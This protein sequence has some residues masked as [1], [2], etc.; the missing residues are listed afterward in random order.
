MKRFR[1]AGGR[2]TTPVTEYGFGVLFNAIRH[3]LHAMPHSTASTCCVPRSS[4]S[5]SVLLRM[6]RMLVGFN[7]QRWCAGK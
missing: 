7:A 6:K 1:E 4:L 5:G 2:M 3:G